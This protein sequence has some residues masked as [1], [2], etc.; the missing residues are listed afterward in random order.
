MLFLRPIQATVCF[1]AQ[2]IV[3]KFQTLLLFKQ[4]LAGQAENKNLRWGWMDPGIYGRGDGPPE[5]HSMRG[6]GSRRNGSPQVNDCTSRL[7]VPAKCFN[8]VRMDARRS[9][10]DVEDIGTHT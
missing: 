3:I 10:F 1:L 6:S 5:K 2:E 4:L 7:N 9:G 8:V